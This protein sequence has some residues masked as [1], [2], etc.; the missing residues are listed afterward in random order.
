MQAVIWGTAFPTPLTPKNVKTSE[1]NGG[2]WVADSHSF[3]VQN[4]PRRLHDNGVTLGEHEAVRSH[5]ETSLCEY[6]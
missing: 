1:R 4:C 6:R 5:A 2:G 3:H